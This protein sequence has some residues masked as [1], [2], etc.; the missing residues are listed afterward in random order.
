L[1]IR[2][3]LLA[4]YVVLGVILGWT[5]FHQR[6]MDVSEAAA[7][8]TA[9]WDNLATPGS[10]DPSSSPLLP[11]HAGRVLFPLLMQVPELLGASP[12]RAFALVRLLTILAALVVFHGFLRRWF[13]D[14]VAF[15]GTLFLAATLP[16]TF[17]SYFEIP[18]DFLEILVVTCGVWALHAQKLLLLCGIVMVGSLNRE[19]TALLPLL[20]LLEGINRLDR[21]RLGWVALAGLAW[22]V[23]VVVMRLWAV[24]DL[25][26]PHGNSM[27]HNVPGLRAVL[28]N[29]HP[30]NNFLFWA[31]L[32][33]AF[34]LLPYLRWQRQP[35]FFRRMLLAVPMVVVVFA[36][37][38]GYLDEPRELVLLY[39]ILVP[40]GLFALFSSRPP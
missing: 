37:T 21:R 17:N 29:P 22:L 30:Y 33:G 19:T 2:G 39:P 3:D 6:R 31:Y 40:T 23:P 18:T 25:S 28:T 11:V 13:S 26:W 5:S 36:L 9:V 4:V 7:L 8:Q 10:L 1:A 38:G 15:S 32:F 35:P 14:E 16:L 34:W 24:G 20:L 12:E 27:V